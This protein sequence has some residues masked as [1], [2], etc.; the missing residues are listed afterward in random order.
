VKGS[1]VFPTLAN[2]LSLVA[3]VGKAA[4]ARLAELHENETV[5]ILLGNTVQVCQKHYAP[6][7]KWRQTAL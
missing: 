4:R 7:V 3:A 2:N 1:C 6:W 5:A